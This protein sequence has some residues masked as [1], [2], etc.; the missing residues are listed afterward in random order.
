MAEGESGRTLGSYR[1]IERIGVG[2]V[3]VG[4]PEY[5]APEQAQ[6]RADSRSDLYALGIILYQML[7]GRVPYSGNS[8]VEVLMKHLQEP[9]PML[10]LRSVQPALPPRVE[11]IIQKALAK[12]PNDRY[13]SGRAMVED[14][15]EAM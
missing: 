11:Q 10:P 4:T 2:G 7:T 3:G 13:G 5:M 9:L 15:I 1:L 6:G 12:N 14:F 8:T